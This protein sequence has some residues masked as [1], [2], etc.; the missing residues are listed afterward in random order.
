VTDGTALYIGT[1]TWSRESGDTALQ[2]F[3]ID[4]ARAGFVAPDLAPILPRSRSPTGR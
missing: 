1:V 4:P 2:T 3:G